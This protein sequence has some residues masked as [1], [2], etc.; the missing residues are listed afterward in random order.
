MSSR[1]AACCA[2]RCSSRSASVPKL[3]HQEQPAKAQKARGQSCP[4]AASASAA[5]G[6]MVGESR[7]FVSARSWQ[8][9][10][11][12]VGAR[13]SVLD[14]VL[15]Q[16]MRMQRRL[17][18]GDLRHDGQEVVGAVVPQLLRL[19]LGR[20]AHLWDFAGSF[21]RRLAGTGLLGNRPRWRL[22]AGSLCCRR[23]WGCLWRWPCLL[24][25]LGSWPGRLKALAGA[26]LPGHGQGRVVND[27]LGQVL[28]RR[29]LLPG[30]HQVGSGSGRNFHQG[31]VVVHAVVQD[32]L[33]GGVLGH[34]LV[35]HLHDAHRPLSWAAAVQRHSPL[36]H[37]G[38]GRDGSVTAPDVRLQLRDLL[39]PACGVF[40]VGGVLLHE[41][42]Q[43]NAQRPAVVP[44]RVAQRVEEA[45]A[46]PKHG[47]HHHRL[48]LSPR[49]SCFLRPLPTTPALRLLVHCGHSH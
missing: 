34:L 30:G 28:S 4:V 1:S 46:V 14:G 35:G 40:L 23:L 5:P 47:D 19:L 44:I 39:E 29:R 25:A 45:V 6:G 15:R 41:V 13:W 42:R 49:T 32:V 9:G 11:S 36:L 2:S 48:H 43:L 33:H 7:S 17:L 22:L 24:G 10:P 18:D 12:M 3:L 21:R 16:A 38:V 20:L 26:L 8:A 37:A 31:V 27:R